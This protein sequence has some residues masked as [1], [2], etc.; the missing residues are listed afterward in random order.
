MLVIRRELAATNASLAHH[1]KG[2]FTSDPWAKA[3]KPICSMKATPKLGIFENV[4]GAEYPQIKL[5]LPIDGSRFGLIEH[6]KGFVRVS[7]RL[8]QVPATSFDRILLIDP[9]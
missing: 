5:F 2:Q 9:Y 8:V 1:G 4:G 6:R 7:G 3:L